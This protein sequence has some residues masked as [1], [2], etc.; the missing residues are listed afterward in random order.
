LQARAGNERADDNRK[1]PDQSD[2]IQS[3]LIDTLAGLITLTVLSVIFDHFG[4]LGLSEHPAGI[5]RV[6][7]CALMV[8]GIGL[9]SWF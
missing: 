7:G 4:W 8:I 6:I 5:G 2:R 9:V 1:V 3:Q